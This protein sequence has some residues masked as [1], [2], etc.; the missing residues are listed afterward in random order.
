MYSICQAPSKESY[1]FN[2]CHNTLNYLQPAFH[3]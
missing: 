1:T 3:K 2:S